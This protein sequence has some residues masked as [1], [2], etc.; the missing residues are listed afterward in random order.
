MYGGK[1]NAAF[2]HHISRNRRVNTTGYKQ[3]CPAARSHRHASGPFFLRTSYISRIIPYLDIY[4]KIG[5]MYIDRQIFKPFKQKSAHF[6][7]DLR[8]F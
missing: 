4:D 3:S 6:L 1:L 5:I 7:A 2:G 8:G